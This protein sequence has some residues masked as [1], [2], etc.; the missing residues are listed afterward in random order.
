[1]KPGLKILISPISRNSLC[2]QKIFLDDQERLLHSVHDRQR[3]KKAVLQE[4]LSGA[5]G[6]FAPQEPD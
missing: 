2:N 4:D 6:P 3:R 5:E 1:M